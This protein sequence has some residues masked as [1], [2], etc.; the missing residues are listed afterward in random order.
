MVGVSVGWAVAGGRVG[1][2]V[3]VGAGVGVSVSAGTGASVGAAVSVSVGVGV[4]VGLSV[5][6]GVME[7]MSVGVKVG[8]GVRV[9]RGD[10]CELVTS[11]G[12]AANTRGS[13]CL[14]S[15]Q[16]SEPARHRP[17]ISKAQAGGNRRAGPASG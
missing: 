14:A 11:P 7:G 6:V 12:A 16:P 17:A 5:G 10:C 15:E 3:A 2:R 13:I 4:A 8:H 1:R 9:A